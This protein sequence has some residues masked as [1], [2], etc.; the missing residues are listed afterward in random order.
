MPST[1]AEVTARDGTRL[2]TRR[3]APAGGA[4]ASM[5]LVHGL[6]EHSARY[7]RTGEALAAAGVDVHAFDLRGHGGSSGRRGDVTRW[8]DLH[9]DVEDG[10]AR[11]RVEAGGAPVA[12][13]GHSFGGLL[14]LDAVLAG[15][16][17]PDLLVL[18][19][20][21][22][23][24]ALPAWQHAVAPVA[25]RIL[26]RLSL[27]N[28]WT[29]ADLSRDPAVGAA[30]D[31]DPLCLRRA[32]VRMGAHGF[33]AQARV[34]GAVDRLSVPTWVHHGSD[35]RLVPPRSTEPLGAVPT[36]TRRVY[37]GLR[38]ECLNEPEG[39][40]VVADLVAWLR[41]QAVGRVNAERTSPGIGG[42]EAV[43]GLGGGQAASSVGVVQ[44][45]PGVD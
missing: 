29:G 36:V 2:L 11:A 16:A 21:G 31:A 40:A 32:T 39:P 5:L 25:A 9:D 19:S 14:V 6:A 35:D 20:P 17:T 24:D 3:W 33:A 27:R 45:A 26:P 4:W 15:R 18:S 8:T 28:A 42:V 1:I 34:R 30:V 12:L 23:A 38:H 13:L 22:L 10:L 44:T 43:P 41:G 7:G 37:P